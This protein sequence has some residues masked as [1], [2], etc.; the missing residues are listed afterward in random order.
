MVHTAKLLGK[1][2]L[3]NACVK[4]AGGAQAQLLAKPRGEDT[5]YIRYHHKN[6]YR[7]GVLRL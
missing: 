4:G 1:D 3:A 7:Y 6:G 2:W 5:V